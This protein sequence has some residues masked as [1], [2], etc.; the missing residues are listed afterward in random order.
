MLGEGPQWLRDLNSGADDERAQQQLLAC[1]AAQSY[2][3]RMLDARP[4]GDVEALLLTSDDAVASLGYLGLAQALAAHPRIGEGAAHPRVG[5]GANAET[6]SGEEQAGLNGADSGVLAALREANAE[7]ERR[8][9]QVYLVC[10]TG[11]SAGELL[12]ICQSRLDNDPSTEQRVV[13]GELAKITRLR[14]ARL[15]A[16]Q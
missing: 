3:A 10:A 5:E 11:R 4:Y 9:G 16:A 7:Y 1:C 6:W 2:V 8:F 15:L 13:L 14:L 12:A